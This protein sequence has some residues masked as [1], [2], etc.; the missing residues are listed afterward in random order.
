M[1]NCSL[2]HWRVH[3]IKR[4][5]FAS[6]T[7]G[8]FITQTQSF[9]STIYTEVHAPILLIIPLLLLGNPS[10]YSLELFPYLLGNPSSV[11]WR[12]SRPLWSLVGCILTPPLPPHTLFPFPNG[13]LLQMHALLRRHCDIGFTQ[14]DTVTFWQIFSS[15]WPPMERVVSCYFATAYHK[16]P[17]IG[18][19]AFCTFSSSCLKI[20]DNLAKQMQDEWLKTSK[21]N[22][23]AITLTIKTK[24]AEFLPLLQLCPGILIPAIYI[25]RN[26]DITHLYI[27]SSPRNHANI[28]MWS[29]CTV[30]LYALS[31][32]QS[33]APTKLPLVTNRK[34]ASSD[35]RFAN[36]QII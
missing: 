6:R 31:E 7:H 1:G 24:P 28:P 22:F 20:L 17:A 36:L 14:S 27:S 23:C 30:H 16:H 25:Y 29:V 26:T 21:I 8:L 34:S 10:L 9:I 19:R 18:R 5:Y 3:E 35:G 32:E 11:L 15:Q 13:S 2:L 12:K 33:W 4:T